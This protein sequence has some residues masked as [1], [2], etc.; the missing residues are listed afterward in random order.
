MKVPNHLPWSRR[1]HLL[2]SQMESIQGGLTE[3]VSK[4]RFVPGSCPIQ[5][6]SQYTTPSGDEL[7]ESTY[8]GTSLV[9]NSAPPGPYSR[10][11]HRAL[12]WPSG[13]G[14]FS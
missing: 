2:S 14:V 11:K 1:G 13:G 12:W 3:V 6:T 5:E 4:S 8:R 10:T 7:G 9:R